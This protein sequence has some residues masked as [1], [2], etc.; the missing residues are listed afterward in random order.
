MSKGYKITIHNR[1]SIWPIKYFFDNHFST[2]NMHI[3][4]SY[5]S[6]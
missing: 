3:L 2:E 1:N 4:M 5:D 6:I